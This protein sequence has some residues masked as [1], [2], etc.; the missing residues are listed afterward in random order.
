[1]INVL[2]LIALAKLDD[3][4][5]SG[6]FPPLPLPS[7]RPQSHRN[8]QAARGAGPK[9]TLGGVDLL[10][11]TVAGEASWEDAALGG[12]LSLSAS[13]DE[14]LLRYRK[15]WFFPGLTDAAT[16]VEVTSSLD[17]HTMRGDAELKVGLRRKFARRGVGIV[18]SLD[19]APGVRADVGATLHLPDEVSVVSVGRGADAPP[20]AA[21]RRGRPG[22]PRLA[23][24][25]LIT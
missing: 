7:R 18:H 10:D 4:G 11:R 1:M 16:R 23:P 22:P 19:L 2:S 17:L 6:N 9:L 5:S 3:A 15:T 8:P 13:A 20:A 12:E 14:R 24:R 25:L 21:R